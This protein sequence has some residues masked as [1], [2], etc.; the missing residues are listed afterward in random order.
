M[1]VKELPLC[2]PFGEAFMQE[3]HI[4]GVFNP[5]VFLKN[6]TTFLTSYPAAIFGLWKDEQLIGGIG[7]MIHPDLNTGQR[8]AVEFFWYVG[9]EHRHTIGSIKL[10]RRWKRWAKENGAVRWRMIHL[11]DVDETASSVKLASFYEKQGL[12][13]IEVG[14][15]GPL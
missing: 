8:I 3:K 11:L 6:W 5:D 15:D 10:V 13:P 12:R 7:G 2:L 1:T 14:F 9:H 4:P